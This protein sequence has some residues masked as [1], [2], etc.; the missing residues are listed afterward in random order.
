M[1]VER[2]KQWAIADAEE[3]GLTG[4]GSL[5]EGLAASLARLR[6]VDWVEAHRKAAAPD[7]GEG[8]SH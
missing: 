4:L 1:F 8:R 5:L 2:W 7:T 6:A 3:R